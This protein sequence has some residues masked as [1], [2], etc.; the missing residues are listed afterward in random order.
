M[1]RP[2]PINKMLTRNI[3]GKLR[4]Y[5]SRHYSSDVEWMKTLPELVSKFTMD[6]KKN[7]D[8]LLDKVQQWF[9]EQLEHPD[10][11]LAK[12][13]INL[14]NNGQRN[15]RVYYCDIPLPCFHDKWT[16]HT[17]LVKNLNQKYQGHLKFKTYT[18]PNI[19]SHVEIEW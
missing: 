9:A 17:M 16:Y 7:D 10:K 6:K 18:N 19:N 1:W 13:V 12:N 15:V 11:Q 2:A 8:I 4:N 3:I 5:S 14:A